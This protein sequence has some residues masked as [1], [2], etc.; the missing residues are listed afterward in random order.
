MYDVCV[1]YIYT[2]FALFSLLFAGCASIT[3]QNPIAVKDV[4]AGEKCKE[5][6]TLVK[7]SATPIPETERQLLLERYKNACRHAQHKPVQITQEKEY[8]YVYCECE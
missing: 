5:R 3:E 2:T 4:N 6:K 8:V 1:K 7:I